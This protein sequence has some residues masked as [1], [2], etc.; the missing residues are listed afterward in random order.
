VNNLRRKNTKLKTNTLFRLGTVSHPEVNV[1]FMG[2]NF[3]FLN[4]CSFPGD[5]IPFPREN[6]LFRGEVLHFPRQIIRFPGEE[7]S[8]T[9]K[10]LPFL[11]QI[12]NFPGEELPNLERQV[13]FLKEILPFP[14]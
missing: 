11:K 1:P 8:L 7:L 12:P 3:T 2:L 6:H 9:G 13:P 10:E 4:R 14:R 5:V